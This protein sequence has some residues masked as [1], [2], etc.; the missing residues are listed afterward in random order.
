MGCLL[1]W[2]VPRATEEAPPV[3]WEEAPRGSRLLPR[4]PH[5]SR[6]PYVW[7]PWNVATPGRVLQARSVLLSHPL[8]TFT[9]TEGPTSPSRAGPS[10]RLPAPSQLGEPGGPGIPAPRRRQEGLQAV[11]TS[12]RQHAGPPHR[13]T[14]VTRLRTFSPVGAV[15]QKHSPLLLPERQGS[16]HSSPH[17]VLRQMPSRVYLHEAAGVSELFL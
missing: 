12:V 7:L 4:T 10:S 5:A 8:H 14:A 1:P 16:A 17:V 2:R 6:A 15:S 9:K 11:S 3:G 13:A